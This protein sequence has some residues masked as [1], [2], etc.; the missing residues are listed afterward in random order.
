MVEVVCSDTY[1][2]GNNPKKLVTASIAIRV[3]ESLSES[4]SCPVGMKRSINLIPT[5]AD[6]GV[7][8]SS[9]AKQINYSP[10]ADNS[11]KFG[12]RLYRQ[13]A[14][15]DMTEPAPKQNFIPRTTKIIGGLAG[16]SDPVCPKGHDYVATVYYYGHK[17]IDGNAYGGIA[18]QFPDWTYFS[19]PENQ[20]ANLGNECSA[21][22]L[23]GYGYW[24]P[25][26]IVCRTDTL[27]GKLIWTQ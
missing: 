17:T 1:P 16:V 4:K 12:N 5:F 24:M 2:S 8:L 26:I 14:C 3:T 9:D 21:D 18:G 13:I 11:F 10:A 27:S 23:V 20:K 6:P 22:G 19:R 25:R 7:F 15:K